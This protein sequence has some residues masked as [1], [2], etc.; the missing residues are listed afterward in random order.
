MNVNK[1]RASQPETNMFIL[2][3]LL[4]MNSVYIVL[5]TEIHYVVKKWGIPYTAHEDDIIKL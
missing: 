2:L 1:S 4:L 3:F 5:Y